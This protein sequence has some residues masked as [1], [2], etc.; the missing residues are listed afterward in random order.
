MCLFWLLNMETS[1]LNQQI[2]KCQTPDRFYHIGF[3]KAELKRKQF[4]CSTCERWKWKS[5]QCNLFKEGV[6]R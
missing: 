3:T 2:K 5:Q 4:F 6:Q 1:A